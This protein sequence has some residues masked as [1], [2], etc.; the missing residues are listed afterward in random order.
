MKVSDFDYILPNEL[1]AQ[2]PVEPRDTSRLMILNRKS[3]NIEH[4]IFRD[5]VEYLNPKD[6]LVLNN[7]RVIPA[8]LFAKKP[9]QQLKYFWLRKLERI[10]GIAWLN[11]EKR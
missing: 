9:I 4:R 8:R 3:R 11:L 5:I 2:N 7:T 10:C 1:I 6:L